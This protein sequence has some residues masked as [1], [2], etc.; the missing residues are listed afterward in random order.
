MTLNTNQDKI[1]PLMAP[2]RLRA[3]LPEILRGPEAA[4]LAQKEL[5]LTDRETGIVGMVLIALQSSI[6][7]RKKNTDFKNDASAI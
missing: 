5:R 4:R 2:Q 7:N 1:S 6:D 3:I